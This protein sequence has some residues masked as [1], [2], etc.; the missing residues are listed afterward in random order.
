MANF[1]WYFVKNKIIWQNSSTILQNY[2][3]EQPFWVLV[4]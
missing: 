1:A 2:F 3:G 4:P